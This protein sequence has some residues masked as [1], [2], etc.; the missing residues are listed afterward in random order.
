MRVSM[1]V[2]TCSIHISVRVL[3]LCMILEE[4]S[5]TSQFPVMTALATVS[6][7]DR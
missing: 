6:E 1:P 7:I 5:A 2:E 4:K 3:L